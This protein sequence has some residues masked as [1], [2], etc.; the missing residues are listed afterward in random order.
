M[1]TDTPVDYNAVIIKQAGT[2]S[3]VVLPWR[4]FA[5]GHLYVNDYDVEAFVGDI[6]Y[7]NGL[8]EISS[9]IKIRD[10]CFCLERMKPQHPAY[11][12]PPH[13]GKPRWMVAAFRGQQHY[14][15]EFIDNVDATSCNKALLAFVCARF[16]PFLRIDIF[17]DQLEAAAISHTSLSFEWNIEQLKEGESIVTM[18]TPGWFPRIARPN[19]EDIVD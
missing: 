15:F 3:D 18:G 4:F 14:S 11:H 12:A 7:A 8:F 19:T 2:S 6:Y 16:L 10:W 17:G 5:A 1:A 9:A 13:S